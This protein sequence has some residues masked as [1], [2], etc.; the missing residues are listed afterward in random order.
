MPRL[1]DKLIGASLGPLSPEEE[2]MIRRH[3]DE[4]AQRAAAL[5]FRLKALKVAAEYEA[6]LQQDE[7]CGDSFSTFVNRFGYQDSDC[8]PMHEYVKRIHKAATPD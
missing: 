3:R 1:H 2:E 6:W 4:K 8:Q 7:E 5:A